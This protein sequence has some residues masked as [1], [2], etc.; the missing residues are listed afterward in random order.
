M[1]T[2]VTAPGS[3]CGQRNPIKLKVSTDNNIETAAVEQQFELLQSTMLTLATNYILEVGGITVTLACVASPP[4][5]GEYEISPFTNQL[6]L[7]D[8]VINQLKILPEFFG[9]FGV[10][11]T[12]GAPTSIAFSQI[13]ADEDYQVSI[14]TWSGSAVGFNIAAVNRVYR[15]NFRL[16]AKIHLQNSFD[17]DPFYSKIA[18]FDGIPDENGVVEW[19]LRTGFDGQLE[20]QLPST[21]SLTACLKMR[22]YYMIEVYERYGDSP[23]EFNRLIVGSAIQWPT[24]VLGGMEKSIWDPADYA[25]NYFIL[26]D[27]KF[28]T[29][30]PR[31]KTVAP[32]QPEWLYFYLR[33]GANDLKLRVVSKR[34]GFADQTDNISLGGA[35]TQGLWSKGIGHDQLDLETLV[36]PGVYQYTV[37]IFDDTTA[38]SEV[39]TQVVDCMGRANELYVLFRGYLGAM[40]TLRCHGEIVRGLEASAIDAQKPDPAFTGASGGEFQQFGSVARNTVNVTTGYLDQEMIEWLRELAASDEVFVLE[41]DTWVRYT[42]NKEDLSD[43]YGYRLPST[44]LNF[45]LVRGLYN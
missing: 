9:K 42:L 37:Q 4:A 31:T 24:A 13:V 40:E 12:Y 15:P 45:S 1:I 25:S 38:L 34:H 10:G 30:R 20:I 11:G 8:Y 19:D 18:E 35:I 5:Y 3:F 22:K 6:Q 17:T 43:L 27:F 33:D 26:L 32:N 2:L 29:N 21:A 16:V 28:L 44:G 39:M 41:G 14:D 7:D 36:G 23:E